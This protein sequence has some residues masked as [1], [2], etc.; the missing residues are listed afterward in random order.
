MLLRNSFADGF[1]ELGPC[2]FVQ[3][4]EGLLQ[5]R[6]FC[7]SFEAISRHGFRSKNL[8]LWSMNLHEFWA[9]SWEKKRID[10]Q[11]KIEHRVRELLGLTEKQYQEIE[12][13]MGSVRTFSKDT[14]TLNIQAADNIYHKL[15][16][17]G[18]RNKSGVVGGIGTDNSLEILACKLKCN[19]DIL[20][21]QI[22]GK[23]AL[24]SQNVADHSRASNAHH[25]CGNGAKC[26]KNNK[27][28]TDPC[29]LRK[30]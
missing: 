1:L 30:A 26:R 8:L 3:E 14:E 15:I 2:P 6:F 4:K 20:F 22:Q 21:Q 9:Y 13:N 29:S 7:L 24:F 25:S 12:N 27:F 5:A 28:S 23:E 10:V 16:D 17:R 18:F 19:P 11:Q